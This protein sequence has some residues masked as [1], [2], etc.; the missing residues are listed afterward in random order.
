MYD[1]RICHCIWKLST[2]ECSKSQLQEEADTSIV[3]HAID[4]T[5]RY[6]FS[7]IVVMCSGTDVLL[8]LLH[9]FEMISNSTIFKTNEHE[10]T[11]CKTY[12]NLIPDIICRAVLGFHGLKR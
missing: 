4:V 12:E 1:R 6:S 2:N 10:Y 8:L 9:Y 11:F 7:E 3:F 5:K